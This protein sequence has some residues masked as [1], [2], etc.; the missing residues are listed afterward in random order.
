MSTHP[1]PRNDADVTYTIVISEQQRRLLQA[2][3]TALIEKCEDY[4]DDQVA[5]GDDE[6]MLSLQDMLDPNGSVGPL[7]PSPAINGLTL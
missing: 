1:N 2:G 6:A 7:A 3:M 5:P 4:T